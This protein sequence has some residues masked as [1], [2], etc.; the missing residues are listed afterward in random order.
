MRFA[1]MLAT[2]L[3]AAAAATSAMASTGTFE[4]PKLPGSTQPDDAIG[5]LAG[6]LPAG[7]A[8]VFGLGDAAGGW[9]VGIGAPGVPVRRLAAYPPKE[10]AMLDLDASPSRIV[11]VRHA[12]ECGSCRYMDYRATLD[13]LISGPLT[14]PLTPIAAWE[15]GQPC[16]AGSLCS[17]QRSRF[18]AALGGDLLAAIDR[19]T[20]TARVTNLATGAG[21][22]LG[23]ATALAVAGSYVAT[24]QPRAQ[25]PA[26][27]VIVRDA[28]SLAESYRAGLPAGGEPFSPQVALLA[29]ATA[30]YM[31][32]LGSQLALVVASPA[33]P[34]G[35][36]LR[37]VPF[38]TAIAGA[39]SG[40]VLLM[41][42]QGPAQLVPLNGGPV[43][44]LA[45]AD[46][47][48]VPAFDG[49]SITWAQ[50]ACVTTAITSWQLGDVRPAGPDLRCPT[51]RPSRAA[52]T[53]ARNRRLSIELACPATGRGGCL[54]DVRLTAIAHARR[55][56]NGA[57]RVYR[58]GHNGVALDPGTRG[59]SDFVVPAGAARW[60]RR[61]A[62]VRLRIDVVSRRDE[63]LPAGDGGQVARTVTLRAAH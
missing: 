36:V 46:L 4:I 1:V 51:P 56:A 35:R 10:N 9:S 58:L 48:G 20:Q 28:S 62:P 37:V 39:G 16:A 60:V 59:R 24:T 13:A 38:A 45:I 31:S 27:T 7:D 34:S 44:E 23:S 22:P 54:A 6:P 11:V 21:G 47:V 43:Q 42:G 40:L 8:V 15:E 61:H 18:V 63:R 53:L 33:A 32:P 2:L 3:L 12:W 41:S 5:V 50:R 29:D 19:C 26:S 55:G 49:R 25:S 57:E 30:V 52:R 14:G 17:G